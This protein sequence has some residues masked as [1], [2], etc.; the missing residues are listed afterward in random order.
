MCRV[1]NFGTRHQP[2]K[3]RVP[4]IV[5]CICIFKKKSWSCRGGGGPGPGGWSPCV[6]SG[7]AVDGD[8]GG[9]PEDDCTIR[10][11]GILGVGLQAIWELG[12]NR[13]VVCCESYS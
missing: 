10:A 3:Y 6:E 13:F 5:A 4:E 12:R 9:L 7:E 2:E 1:G 11:L 8:G